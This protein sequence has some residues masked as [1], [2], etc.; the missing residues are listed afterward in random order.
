MDRLVLY[1]LNTEA[2]RTQSP[3]IE[4]DESLTAFV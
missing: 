4:L 3:L 2:L 1:R